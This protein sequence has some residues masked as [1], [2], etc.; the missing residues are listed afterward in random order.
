MIIIPP[1]LEMLFYAILSFLF[2]P[3]MDKTTD[4][5]KRLKRLYILNV[6]LSRNI[7]SNMYMIENVIYD[8]II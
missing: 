2:E 8:S 6:Y 4:Q 3:L 7:E 5:P 1:T